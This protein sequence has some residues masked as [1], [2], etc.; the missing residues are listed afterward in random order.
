MLLALAKLRVYRPLASPLQRGATE[1][2]FRTGLDPT[3]LY[4]S[5][6]GLFMFRTTNSYTLTAM[7]GRDIGFEEGA[8][9]SRDA[10][11]PFLLMALRPG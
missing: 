4:I 2:C 9:A 8:A 7:L 11:F 10:A 5:I 6:G 3:E 1:G